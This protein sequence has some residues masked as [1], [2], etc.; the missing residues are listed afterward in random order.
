[1]I[2]KCLALV[3]AQLK[4]ALDFLLY[5]PFYKLCNCKTDEMPAI[6]GEVKICNYEPNPSSIEDVDC[7]VC[8]CKI[9]EGEEIGV[10]RCEHFFHR[11]CL[12]R[13]VGFKVRYATCPICRDLV[14]QS[15]E[16]TEHGAEV[17]EFQFWSFSSRDRD[18]W[19]LR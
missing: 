2:M 14:G 8:L 19:W 17:I 10:L 3:L 9:R 15:R 6:K 12:E 1:M 11:I 16:I 5:H 4:W 13:W 18:R 7:A